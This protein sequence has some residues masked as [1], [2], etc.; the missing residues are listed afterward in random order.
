MTKEVKENM[1]ACLKDIQSGKFAKDWMD[2][3][4]EFGFKKMQSELDHLAK[5]DMETVGMQVRKIMWPNN[6][7]HQ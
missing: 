3:Y 6:K 2:E 7:E 1:K 4:N 5:H